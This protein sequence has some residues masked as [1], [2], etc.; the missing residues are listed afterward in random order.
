MERNL[1][2]FKEESPDVLCL[3]EV[4]E[5]DFHMFKKE[6]GM[7]GVFE[8]AC[9]SYFPH[10]DPKAPTEETAVRGIAILSKHKIL[11]HKTEYYYGEPGNL[12]LAYKETDVVNQNRMLLTAEID[13]GERV[14]TIA[15]T[16]FPKSDKKPDDPKEELA[17]DFQRK[18]LARMLKYLREYKSLILTGDLNSPR[19]MEIYDSLYDLFTDHVPEKYT[20]SLD[21]ELHFLGTR[22]PYMIDILFSTPDIEVSACELREGVSDHK[23]IVALLK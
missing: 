9:V 4:F 14:Y 3:Q 7:E 1:P 11:D 10:S 8:P 19:G 6:L 18:C 23:A 21:P 13:G 22:F 5:E 16:H 15:T 2:F 12:K 20:C 17:N